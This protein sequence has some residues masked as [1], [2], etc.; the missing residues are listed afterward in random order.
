M[1][2]RVWIIALVAVLLV[3]LAFVAGMGAYLFSRA[4]EGK[5][6]FAGGNVAL[7]S[8]EGAIFTADDVIEELDDARKDDDIR[9]V[10]LRLESPGGSVAASQEI[11]EAVRRLAEAKPVVASMGSVAAS[12]AYYIACGATKILASPGT[13]TGS[14]GVRMD[15]LEISELLS[16][17]KVHHETLKSGAFKDLAAFDRPMTEKER[18]IL[19]RLLLDLHEQFKDAVAELRPIERG[20]V[21]RIADGRVYSGNQ[22][23][24]LKLI[25]QLGGFSEAVKL[26]GELGGIKGEPDLVKMRRPKYGF[27]KRIFGEAKA[28]FRDE[29]MA[30]RGGFR[31][32]LM[33]YAMP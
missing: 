17:A 13:I 23:L 29:M 21:D 3:G 8:I 7:V 12:G 4:S 24:K 28:F 31:V 11:L 2:H 9:A 18:A 6:V 16:F 22:A 5:P 27:V 14:I 19:D 30:A 15:H 33:L 10:V 26:A 20:E 32:P 25:D 1:R